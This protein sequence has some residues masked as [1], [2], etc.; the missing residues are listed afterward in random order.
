[1]D[2]PWMFRT[3]HVPG[4]MSFL[5]ILY[6]DNVGAANL[7]F[8]A[9]DSPMPRH[10]KPS[11]A[12]QKAQTSQSSH[13]SDNDAFI[14]Q[15]LEPRTGEP[16]D[17]SAVYPR[18]LLEEAEDGYIPRQEWKVHH[19]PVAPELLERQEE[20]LQV[21]HEVCANESIWF[22]YKNRSFEDIPNEELEN[23]LVDDRHGIIYCFV[24][25]VA[26][27][28]WKRI[29]IV[30][31]ESLVQNGVPQRDPMAIPTRLTYNPEFH[32]SLMKFPERY[33][34]FSRHLMK[35]KLRKYTK[36]LFVRDP[37]VR[38]ISVFRDK[39]VEANDYYY[40]AYGKLLLHLY[41]NQPNPPKNVRESIKMGI[42]PTFYQFIQFLIDTKTERPFDGHWRQMHR[43]CHPCQ[44]QYDFVGHLETLD[45][46]TKHLLRLLR[47]DNV[48]EFPKAG[49]RNVSKSSWVSDWFKG[50]PVDELRKLYKLFEPDFRL[51]GYPRP[52]SILDD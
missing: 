41:G 7:N 31:T 9:P 35:V 1:M 20:R 33:G 46:D 29:M 18:N 19:S 4:F 2:A 23:L 16:K 37:F 10:R 11:P 47:V 17:P 5:I 49:N 12:K 26:C 21:I 14:N 43:L 39:F 22:P 8:L 28:N 30:L 13:R 40:N 38:I 50:I 44:I 48:V 51:F 32:L 42:H 36:F 34:R 6:W 3:L 24:P 25:K 15:F 27:T 45:E 52:D